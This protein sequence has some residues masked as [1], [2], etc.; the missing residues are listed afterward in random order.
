MDENEEATFALPYLNLL[1]PVWDYL[2]LA[3]GAGAGLQERSRD[4]LEACFEQNVDYLPFGSERLQRASLNEMAARVGCSPLE[5]MQIF[6]IHHKN[7]LLDY[8]LVGGIHYETMPRAGY[9]EL[10]R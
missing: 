4:Y 3:T 2:L 1:G 6:A 9:L 7:G 5:L 8:D 10:D